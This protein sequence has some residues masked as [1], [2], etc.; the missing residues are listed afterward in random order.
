M[1]LGR[2]KQELGE[3]HF[4]VRL[5]TGKQ[6]FKKKIFCEYFLSTFLSNKKLIYNQYLRDILR[7]LE[8]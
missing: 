3:H 2:L 6:L 8:L 1:P 7:N 5:V 4:K